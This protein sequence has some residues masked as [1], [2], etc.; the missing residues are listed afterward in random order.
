MRKPYLFQLVLWTTSLLLWGWTTAVSAQPPTFAELLANIQTTLQT[1][2]AP[3]QIQCLVS[4]LQQRETQIQAEFER[5]E[6]HL[7]ANHLPDE[8]HQRHRKTVANHSQQ[9]E[10]LMASLSACMETD[11]TTVCQSALTQISSLLNIVFSN[12]LYA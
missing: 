4:Q 2:T 1:E 8:L 6:T 9:I 3:T 5:I 11:D 12:L 7:S 10:P